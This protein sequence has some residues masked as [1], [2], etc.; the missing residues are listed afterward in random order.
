[1]LAGI[2]IYVVT[3]IEKKLRMSLKFRIVV[4]SGEESGIKDS[5]EAPWDEV[6]LLKL[7]GTYMSIPV[8]FLSFCM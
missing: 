7:S 6:L 3:S 8:V 2:H 1:M 4:I 5:K